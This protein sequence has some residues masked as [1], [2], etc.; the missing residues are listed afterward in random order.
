[1]KKFLSL[2]GPLVLFVGVVAGNIPSMC[3]AYQPKVPV[4]LLKG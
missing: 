3:G 2:F 4:K 1:M